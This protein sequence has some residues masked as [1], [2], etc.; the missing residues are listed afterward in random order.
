MVMLVRYTATPACI[1]DCLHTMQQYGGS[2]RWL[3]QA[4]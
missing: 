4:L 2:S 3:Q 1:S